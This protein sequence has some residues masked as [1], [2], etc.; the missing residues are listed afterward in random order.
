[1][2]QTQIVGLGDHSKNRVLD[3]EEVC[4]VLKKKFAESR[5]NTEPTDWS[6]PLIKELDSKKYAL[7]MPSS[8]VEWITIKLGFIPDFEFP[9]VLI[10]KMST[11]DLF[12]LHDL[13]LFV[14]YRNQKGSENK[15]F[16]DVGANIGLHSVVAYLCGYS[17]T[18]FEPDKETYKL[19]KLF[20]SK[21]AAEINFL[22]TNI[23]LIGESSA[24]STSYYIQ[25]AVSDSFDTKIFVR[26]LDNPYGNHLKGKKKNIYGSMQETEVE[27]V[28]IECYIKTM[29][30]VKLDAE[31]S[32][33]I[34]LN[35]LMSCAESIDFCKEIYLCDWRDETRLDIHKAISKL[36][37]KYKLSSAFGEIVVLEDLPEN[38][39]TDYVRLKKIF[40]TN[41]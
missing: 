7:S 35:K 32:D 8:Q 14:D 34:I 9:F 12:T 27:S 22:Q 36:K 10:G 37:T 2:H 40:R 13:A 20:I 39:S 38:R 11:L 15:K 6:T 31:G 21:V 41:A 3:L 5:I 17:I 1:V 4:L 24:H 29:C 33:L 30:T 16:I 23:K 19:G 28:D 18:A 26:F 25:A